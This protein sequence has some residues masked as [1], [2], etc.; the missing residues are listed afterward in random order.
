MRELWQR[1][2][3]RKSRY[4]KISLDQAAA[5]YGSPGAYLCFSGALS[6]EQLDR[7]RADWAR[8]HG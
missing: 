1:W 2:F 6:D 3:G 7:L 8:Y 5:K 4:P